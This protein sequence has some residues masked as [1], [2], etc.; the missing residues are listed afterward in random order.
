MVDELRKLIFML[1][2]YESL[3]L[4]TIFTTML[5]AIVCGVVIYTVYRFFYRG[6]VYSD[7]LGILMVLVTVITAFIIITIGSNLVL[8]LG[9]VGALSIVRFRAAIKEPLDVGFIYWGVTA[10][11]SAGARLYLVALIGTAAVGLIYILMTFLHRKN[12]TFLLILRYQPDAE[13]QVAML[14]EKTRYK[15][16]NKICHVD[17]VEMTSEVKISKNQTDF[18]QPF[19]TNKTINSATLV[20]YTG[21]YN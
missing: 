15:L 10:G 4:T 2:Q 14:M 1:S 12:K 18:L 20:E 17:A 16:K 8:S 6:V 3:S 9:M 5:V 21:D 19:L 13:E 11:L 7:N